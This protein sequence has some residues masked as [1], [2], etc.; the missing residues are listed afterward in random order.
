M[1][2]HEI[3]VIALTAAAVCFRQA[4]VSM[5]LNRPS[6]VRGPGETRSQRRTQAGHIPQ[7]ANDTWSVVKAA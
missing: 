7:P 5:R 4:W 2:L 1:D 3:L 6:Q